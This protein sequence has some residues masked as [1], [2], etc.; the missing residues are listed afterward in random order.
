MSAMFWSG[1][2]GLRPPHSCG[3]SRADHGHRGALHRARARPCGLQ[4]RH[5]LQFPAR[6]VRGMDCHGQ[7]APAAIE[8]FAEEL[9]RR[10]G[11][12]RW[13][14]AANPGGAGQAEVGM[15]E[16]L[17]ICSPACQLLEPG[18]RRQRT[19]RSTGSVRP[20]RQGHPS[21]PFSEVGPRRTPFGTASPSCCLAKGSW[22]CGRGFAAGLSA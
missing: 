10:A 14:V 12:E 11:A 6:P 20:R 17:R 13:A 1:Q 8:A 19:S 2:A 22:H 16:H 9:T 18:D 4:V 3:M 21:S 7:P 15:L 5:V